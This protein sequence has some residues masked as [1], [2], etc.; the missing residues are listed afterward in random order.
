[1]TRMFKQAN[2]R[3]T[4]SREMMKTKTTIPLGETPVRRPIP[5]AMAMLARPRTVQKSDER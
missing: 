1:M 4:N 5:N 2:S 3:E